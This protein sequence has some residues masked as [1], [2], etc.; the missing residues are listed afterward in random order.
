MIAT[1][2][3]LECHNIAIWYHQYT[4][5]IEMMASWQK[6]D[7]PHTILRV[8]FFCEYSKLTVCLSVCLF[9]PPPHHHHHHQGEEGKRYGE[10]K[11]GDGSIEHGS[12]A[13]FRSAFDIIYTWKCI[14]IHFRPTQITNM[15]KNSSGLLNGQANTVSSLLYFSTKSISKWK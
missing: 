9:S 3:R 1:S 10:I 15:L 6:P 7:I 13:F 14:D 12:H 5:R 11:H 2:N 4:S 8:V